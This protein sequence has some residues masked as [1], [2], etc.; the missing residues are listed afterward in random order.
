MPNFNFSYFTT[1][2]MLIFA[3][4]GCEKLSPYVN[5]TN[6]PDKEFPKG[7]IVLAIGGCIS[8]YVGIYSYGSMMFDSD[9]IPEDLMM[10]G[11]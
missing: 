11:Q 10:N 1:L 3:V 4:G 9:N 8:A 2:S 5:D 6:N 7:M